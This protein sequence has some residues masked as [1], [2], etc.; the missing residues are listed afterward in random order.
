MP[1]SP[2]RALAPS[3]WFVIPAGLLKWHADTGAWDLATRIVGA[4]P[5][6]VER[7]RIRAVA[8]GTSFASTDV[9][10]P[11]HNDLQL[12]LGCPADLQILCCVRQAARGGESLLFDTWPWLLELETREPA[13]FA[14]LFESMRRFPFV[15]GPV[16][17]TTVALFAERLAFLCSPQPSPGD[18]VGERVRDAISRCRP[19]RATL[20]AG[21][22]LVVDN[23]R[24]L[25][26][27]TA[28]ADGDR[29]LVR[30]LVWLRE[31]GEGRVAPSRLRAQ[32][33][34]THVWTATATAEQRLDRLL[35]MLGGASPGAVAR[36]APGGEAELYRLRDVAIRAALAALDPDEGSGKR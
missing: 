10:T 8:G 29:E 7:Q 18:I 20:G 24:T 5:R 23:H 35:R 9:D 25:H 31:P 15:A 14:A 2:L 27:R 17:S 6:M 3:G 4:S 34:P 30:L 12:H 22:I 16:H 36:E 11:L 33:R 32:A 21:E 26:G 13:L 19:G 28:F 1:E